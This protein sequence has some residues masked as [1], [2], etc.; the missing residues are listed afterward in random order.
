MTLDK[1]AAR[2]AWKERETEWTVYAARTGGATWVGVTSDLQAIENRLSFSLR[3][4]GCRTKGMQA[5]FDG[6]LQVDP[7]E[8]LDPTLGP[9]ARQDATKARRDHWCAELGATPILR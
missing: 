6:T 2:T 4:G 8:T 5:A 7:L 1:R 3:T 9:L